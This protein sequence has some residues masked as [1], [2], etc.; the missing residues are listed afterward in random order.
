MTILR[1]GMREVAAGTCHDPPKRA[2]WSSGASPHKSVRITHYRRR[3]RAS[4]EAGSRTTPGVDLEAIEE[5][6]S[7]SLRYRLLHEFNLSKGAV[8]F[9]V[10]TCRV[11]EDIGRPR[12]CANPERNRPEPIDLDLAVVLVLKTATRTEFTLFVDTVGVD[13]AIAEV[14]D[15]KTSAELSKVRRSHRQ[16]P[17]RVQRPVRRHLREQIAVRVEL[18]HEAVT[19]AGDVIQSTPQRIG[20]ENGRA[21]RL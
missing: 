11:V 6:D 14:A 7:R 17:W 21:N 12:A 9:V 10:G 15:Q 2:R 4:S 3:L 1:S 19:D 18:T 13:Q 20:H 5:I 16:P 8:L